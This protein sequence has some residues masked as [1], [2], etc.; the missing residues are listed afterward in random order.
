MKIKIQALFFAFSYVSHLMSSGVMGVLP[1]V[2]LTHRAEL[3]Q[4]GYFVM[5]WTP[6]EKDILIELQV[7]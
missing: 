3:D 4:R 1:E 7:I 5:L 2:T 6:R